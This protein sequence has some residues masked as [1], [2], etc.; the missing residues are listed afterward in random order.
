MWVVAIA[1]Y[2]KSRE[3]MYRRYVVQRKSEQEIADECGV[4]LMTIHTW[5][6]KHKLLRNTRMGK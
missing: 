2:Y 4:T 1:A 3:W 5:L 6:N